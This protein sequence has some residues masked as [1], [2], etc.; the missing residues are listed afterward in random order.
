ML[1]NM[2]NSWLRPYFTQVVGEIQLNHL[3]VPVIFHFIPF[4]ISSSVIFTLLTFMIRNKLGHVESCSAGHELPSTTKPA[5]VCSVTHR[6]VMAAWHE[7]RGYGVH[8]EWIRQSTRE[9]GICW[10]IVSRAA[11]W[12]FVWMFYQGRRWN[13]FVPF[14]LW[15]SGV[16]LHH[17]IDEMLNTVILTA[18]TQKQFEWRWQ[19]QI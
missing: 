1:N 12:M 8:A 19:W 9:R 11:L 16:K 2:Q 6:W 15:C 18:G 7:G 13:N 17:C 10:Y 5:S 4:K 14:D 3:S